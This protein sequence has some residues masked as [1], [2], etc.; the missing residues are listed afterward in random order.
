MPGYVAFIQGAVSRRASVWPPPCGPVESMHRSLS[1]QQPRAR[2]LE[3]HGRRL[4]CMSRRSP[5]ST[6]PILRLSSS[7]FAQNWAINIPSMR[8]C[9][10]L[11]SGADGA[12]SCADAPR[13][14]PS[15]ELR[16][17]CGTAI[18]P[19]MAALGQGRPR[20][21]SRSGMRGERREHQ[22][23]CHG[24]GLSCSFVTPRQRRLQRWHA[25]LLIKAVLVCM[26][27]GGKQQALSS[28]N[29]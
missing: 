6:G 8:S 9:W 12:R 3:T 15:A 29:P 26:E 23:Y 13:S 21:A 22:C 14:E 25:T 17:A 18:G 7:T 10:L 28:V 19:K 5:A 20:A 1:I 4:S 11:M 2:D 27:L 24:A 16:T